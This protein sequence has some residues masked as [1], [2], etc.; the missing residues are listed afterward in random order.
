MEIF[1]LTPRVFEYTVC[2]K[3][4]MLKGKLCLKVHNLNVNFLRNV[5]VNFIFQFF[6]SFLFFSV[7]APLP[8][9]LIMQVPSV[10]Y[11]GQ[12]LI[13]FTRWTMLTELT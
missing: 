12:C 11:I 5:K 4:I 6:F 3:M 9:F 1:P 2:S 13:Q 10:F 8:G 7:C